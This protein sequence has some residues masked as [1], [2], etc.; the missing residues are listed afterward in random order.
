[1]SFLG[2]AAGTTYSFVAPKW[3][4]A[5]LSVVPSVSSKGGSSGALSGAAAALG[6]T[7]L[8]VDLGGSSDVD[9][10]DAIFRSTSV[11]DAVIAK[12]GLVARYRERYL[13]DTREEL[14][15][16]CSTRLDKKPALVTLAC[17]DKS[18]DV[19]M[20]IVAYFADNANQVARRISTSSAGEERRFLET[21]VSQARN[22]L[23]EASRNLR[24]FQEQNKVISLPE[25]ARA[26]V[27]S[28]ATL[29]A[30]MLEKQ[31]QLAYVDGYSSND[32][33]TSGQLRQQVGI[34]QAK[35][36]SLE[37]AHVPA[38]LRAPNPARPGTQA[39]ADSRG[40]SSIFPPAMNV[41]MLQYK[42]EQL[43]REQKMQESL[44][45]LLMQRWELA[46]VQEAR[47][48]S[49]MQILDHPIRPTKKSRPKRAISMLL[50]FLTGLALG[51]I[52]RCAPKWRSFIP[53]IAR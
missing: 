28:M 40:A 52:G 10:I 24:E 49:T 25:Q 41:P 13:E 44:V 50:G 5:E 21:R 17:E 14:W 51:L 42:L 7:D 16:H 18:P 1:M 11:T 26:I 12:F 8:S 45:T 32:E 6:A 2:L 15:K 36:K 4:T 31:L 3:Y 34:L 53:L 19:A 47:D 22:N 46:R 39:N 29:R 23:D 20:A 33:S 9:R 38:D 27:T 35:L 37:Q 48:T 30:E 43:L